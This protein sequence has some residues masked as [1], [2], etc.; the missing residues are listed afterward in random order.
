MA[1][2]DGGI[3][4]KLNVS[5]QAI[6]LTDWKNEPSVVD[7]KTDLE[8]SKPYH[9][10]H[11]ARIR[12]WND[13]LKVEG[14]ARPTK[15]K[16]RSSVQPKLVRRQAEWR[17]SA[18]T[19]PFLGS[20]KL[21]KISP[22]TFEDESA[23]SQN[24]LVLN[25]QFRTKLNR[26]KFIDDFV[27]AVVDDGTCI[28]RLSWKRVTKKVKTQVPVWDHFPIE[29]QQQM[30]SLGQAMQLKQDNPRGFE[31]QVPEE[32]KAAVEYLEESG[33]P[34][35]AKQ[36]GTK[37]VETEKIVFNQ[38]GV[39]VL[40]VANVFVD[41]SCLG[42]WDKA[43]F[44]VVSFETNKSELEKSSTKYKNLDKVDW[45]SNTPMTDAYHVTPTSDTNFSFKDPARK[46]V[47]A[48]EYWGYY[49]IDGSGELTPFVATWIG[50]T[51]IRM[52]KN[53]FPDE[54]I[55]LVLVPYM[56]IKRHLFGEPD[57]ELLGD[58]QAILGAVTRGM[59]DLLGRSANGQ[60]GFAKG[61]LDPFNRRRYEAGQ[62]YEF[63]PN[64]NPAVGLIEHKYPEIPNSA[65]AMLG[66]QNQEAEALTG[67]KS[68]A[69]G[70]SGESY[71]DLAATARGAM[72]AA[73]KR[74]M[75]I[76]RRLAKGIQDIGTKIV[77]MNGEFLSEEET[78]RVTNAT[79]VKV[80]REDLK[81]NFDLEVDIS[82]AEVDDAKAKDLGFMLQTCGPATGP[83]V[84]ML[85]LSEIAD[86]KRMPVLAHKLK[87]WQPPPPDPAQVQFQQQMQQLELQKAQA[88]IE[89]IQ[90]E[91][92]VNQAKAHEVMAS[93]GQKDLDV[94]EQETG[95]K[96]A[97]DMEQMQAQGRA[98]QALEITKALTRPQ[99]P[100]EG[101]PDL[102]AAI[103]FNKMSEMMDRSENLRN[104]SAP[105]QTQVAPQDNLSYA[106]P[107]D[108]VASQPV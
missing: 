41:P 50:S 91:I 72:D 48:Y 19:E 100:D 14:A 40:N 4:P 28:V 55:P 84:I 18:L 26:V 10:A 82:T 107:Q 11:I 12:I 39:E 97:R 62:D 29:N 49:D 74:E 51:L 53:P 33:Q 8:A 27:R 6:K 70:I 57:A 79:F 16:G 42:D 75:A 89:K 9:D 67:V 80:S 60:Q 90:S 95:T 92:A 32:L 46:K 17:Y 7:L 31:E 35:I 76:L 3:Q 68:F 103:G 38:P 45:A 78:V 59:I 105:P 69:G 23:A 66:L 54:K 36:N 47:V 87:T 94:L 25:W 81:G 71:G 96:H 104:N 20:T 15:V 2:E 64:S 21:F 106:L 1:E 37:E 108:A 44:A 65:M 88:E 85:I 102:A 13:L 24:E 34:T 83:E 22:V 101:T 30:D 58:N 52:E 99:K 77:A 43:L 86:L 56:P 93:K 63:N 5:G 73:S 61:M 98:N